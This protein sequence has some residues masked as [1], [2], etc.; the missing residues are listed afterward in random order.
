MWHPAM[1]ADPVW[2]RHLAVLD[3]ALAQARADGAATDSL[4][5]LDAA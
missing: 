3:A 5:R 1:D 2:S 4:A